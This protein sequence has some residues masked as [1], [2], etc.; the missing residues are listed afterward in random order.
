MRAIPAG[1]TDAMNARQA[2]A[3][4]GDLCNLVL[5]DGTCRHNQPATAVELKEDGWRIR[6]AGI[7]S[8]EL[9]HQQLATLIVFVCTGNTCRSPMAAGL[10]RMMLAKCLGCSPARLAAHGWEVLS[11]GVWADDGRPASAEAIQAARKLGADLSDHRSRKLTKDLID[12]ADVIFC[13]SR[14]HIAAVLELAPASAD[15]VRRLLPRADIPDPMGGGPGAYQRTAMKM[16]Q[17]V[18]EIVEKECHGTE[19]RTGG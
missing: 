16:R 2:L 3:S 11:A 7:V 15:K 4:A 12:Q 5:D 19:N 9:I 8:E 1:Q 17:A 6:R 13:M 10:A 14:E 18:R